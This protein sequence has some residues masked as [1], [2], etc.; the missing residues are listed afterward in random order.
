LAVAFV[1]LE[2]GSVAGA[3]VGSLFSFLGFRRCRFASWESSAAGV[4]ATFFG[5]GVEAFAVCSFDSTTPPADPALPC[6]AWLGVAA[7]LD[8]GC[9][10]GVAVVELGPGDEG[11]EAMIPGTLSNVLLKEVRGYGWISSSQLYDAL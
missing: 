5:V 1:V 9:F 7:F 8:L 10:V 2:G 4:A 3:G 6:S 11:L